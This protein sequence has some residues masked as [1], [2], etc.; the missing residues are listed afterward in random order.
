MNELDILIVWDH[1]DPVEAQYEMDMSELEHGDG[2]R[3]E[4]EDGQD[5]IR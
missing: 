2:D 1:F 3:E 4:V 5:T